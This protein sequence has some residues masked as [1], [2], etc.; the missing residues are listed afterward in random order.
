[1]S[2]NQTTESRA[3]ELRRA[4]DLTFREL[5]RQGNGDCENLL[6]T[7][8]ANEH[9]AVCTREIA[10]L[11]RCPTIVPIPSRNP[12]L[13]G[14]AGICGEPIAVF[15]LAALMGHRE[16]DVKPK[17]LLL[18]GAGE[19]VGFSF[20][21]VEGHVQMPRS[22]LIPVTDAGGRPAGELADLGTRTRP[23]IK[24]AG[25]LEMIRTHKGALAVRG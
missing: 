10:G 5:P 2:D 19:R 12:A 21:E 11:I 13:V 23:V 6:L 20:A 8:V 3:L 22:R 18:C 17:L 24:L 14:I 16:P 15:S 1:V 25:L 9:Y 4:F 7:R